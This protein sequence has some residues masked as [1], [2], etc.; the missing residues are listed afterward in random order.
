MHH[1]GGKLTQ[2][3]TM[4]EDMAQL[5]RVYFMQ[6]FKKLLLDN[7]HTDMPLE[8]MKA[9][10]KASAAIQSRAKSKRT[11]RADIKTDKQEARQRAKQIRAANQRAQPTSNPEAKAEREAVLAEKRAQAGLNRVVK[12]KDRAVRADARAIRQAERTKKRPARALARELLKNE[13]R[14][15]AVKTR[16]AQ[17]AIGAKENAVIAK[18][19][20]QAV[21]AIEAVSKRRQAMLQNLEGQTMP[22]YIRPRVHKDGTIVY[23]KK[24]WEPPPVPDGYERKTTNLKSSDAWTFVPKFANCKYRVLVEGKSMS[25]GCMAMILHC[26][27]T[28]ELVKIDGAACPACDLHK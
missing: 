1:H 18:R 17:A 2:A 3:M 19:S 22:G 24:G 26:K 16:E 13:R 21:L 14:A 28:G 6:T 11:R 20:E 23:P 9:L 7:A 15:E 4:T 10:A 27:R 12:A 8:D 25:C 5:E